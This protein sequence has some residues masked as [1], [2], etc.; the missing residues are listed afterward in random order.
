MEL[1]EL[2]EELPPDSATGRAELGDMAGWSMLASNVAELVD[3][4]THWLYAK[5]AEWT[6][7]PEDPETKRRNEARKRA[8]YKPPPIPIIAPVAIR[9]PSLAAAYQRRYE[10]L[11]AQFR[12]PM[13]DVLTEGVEVRPGVRRVTSDM[14]T[15]A[16]GVEP[17]YLPP[18]KNKPGR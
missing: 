17:T 7:D 11:A 3:L 4:M 13:V 6:T 1:A 10:E 12:D 18:R 16:L 9:P 5:H 2:L 15:K 14:F 8:G